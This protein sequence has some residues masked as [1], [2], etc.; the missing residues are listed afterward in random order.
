MP[1][2]AVSSGFEFAPGTRFAEARLQLARLHVGGDAP[3][4]SVLRRITALAAEALEVERASIWLFVHGRIALR[5]L[6]LFERSRGDHSEGTHLLRQDYPRYFAALES[7]D[8]LRADDA[9]A[10]PATRGLSAT[11]LEPLGVASML[12]APIYRSGELAGVVC[13]EHRGAPRAWTAEE[14]A[15]A[16][17]VAEAIARQLEEAAR[18]RIEQVLEARERSLDEVGRLEA[19]GRM[20]SVVSHDFRNL[21]TI[22]LGHAGILE[23]MPDLPEAAHGEL[24]RLRTAAERGVA[25]TRELARMTRGDE[26]EQA[27]VVRAR[28]VVEGFLEVLR[29]LAGRGHPL[30]FDPGADEGRVLVS[31]P[32]L[33]RALIDLV[34]H[35]AGVTPGGGPIAVRIRERNLDPA[36]L[37][38]GAA[39]G[40]GAGAE[41]RA[42][43]A[44]AFVV[45]EVANAADAA[46]AAG[47]RPAAAV[48]VIEP[49]GP[50]PD[51]GADPGIELAMVYRVVES[52]GGFVTCEGGSGPGTTLSLYLPRVAAR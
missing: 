20:A 26:V 13:H 19:L 4:R 39:G 48:R 34:Q 36:A 22:V 9:R 28:D 33:E 43:A 3:L 47:A 2:P 46:D 11:Y 29:P 14:C 17:T 23:S 31:P 40:G 45:V 15:F 16:S 42:E 27:Q 24:A 7:H 44:G 41:P 30:D 38:A 10:H 52:A 6:D 25:L 1:D 21:L 49:L 12:D 35:V 50:V 32:R 5:C 8:V 18:L 51:E 37:P